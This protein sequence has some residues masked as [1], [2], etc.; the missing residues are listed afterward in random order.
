MEGKEK[1]ETP[2]TV[3]IRKDVLETLL[4]A[5]GQVRMGF[6]TFAPRFAAG[7]HWEDVAVMARNSSS[8]IGEIEKQLDGNQDKKE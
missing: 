6:L 7:S 1:T 8:L 5:F 2:E 3:V 4:R